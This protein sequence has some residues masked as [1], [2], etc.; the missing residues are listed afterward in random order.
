MRYSLSA[1]LTLL[2]V[3]A[4]GSQPSLAQD[5]SASK[6]QALLSE[7]DADKN[8]LWRSIPWKTNLLAAQKSAVETS[9]PIFIWAMDGHP[10][11]CT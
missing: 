8:A 1:F 3:L 4:W 2:T 10:L 11:G 7:L 6:C 5:L 9:K